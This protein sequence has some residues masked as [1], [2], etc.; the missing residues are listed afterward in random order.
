[1]VTASDRAAAAVRKYL[2]GI[3]PGFSPPS[4]PEAVVEERALPAIYSPVAAYLINNECRALFM[5]GE[6]DFDDARLLAVA[7][8]YKTLVRPLSRLE[9]L[10]VPSPGKEVEWLCEAT[11]AAALCAAVYHA[12][13]DD[14]LNPASL[15]RALG[16]AVER[17]FQVRLKRMGEG[18]GQMDQVL[19]KHLLPVWTLAAEGRELIRPLVRALNH[20]L[21]AALDE[22]LPPAEDDPAERLMAERVRVWKK[23]KVWFRFQSYEYVEDLFIKKRAG[24]LE[25]YQG[26]YALNQSPEAKVDRVRLRVL[27]AHEN[28]QV[29]GKNPFAGGRSSMTS[30]RGEFMFARRTLVEQHGLNVPDMAWAVAECQACQT[31]SRFRSEEDPLTLYRAAQAM[32]R[33]KQMLVGGNRMATYHC[34]RCRQPLGFEHLILAAYAHHL[35]D[36]GRDIYFLN[37]RR[38]GRRRSFI[39]FM[40]EGE[41]QSHA[42][43]ITDQ[44]IAKLAGRP[45]SVVDLWRELLQRTVKKPEWKE[46]GP[47]FVGL[48]LP[49]MSP[50]AASSTVN[51]F[52]DQLVSKRPGFWPV[53]LTGP[54]P[55]AGECVA[56]EYP[57]WLADLSTKVSCD[58]GYSLCAFADM[59]RI[60]ALFSRAAQKL[61]LMPRRAFDGTL[62]VHGPEMN[63]MVDLRNPV[64]L[65][66]LR[67]HFPGT[68]AAREAGLQAKRLAHAESTLQAVRAYLGRGFSVQYNPTTREVVMEGRSGPPFGIPLDELVRQ[69]SDDQIKTRRMIM[70]KVGG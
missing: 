20:L 69:W 35:A 9:F 57:A 21:R 55:S 70:A 30:V 56:H 16:A 49:P 26:L 2:E 29:P 7:A 14:P 19:E 60:E 66:V 41:N 37:E 11:P 34:S 59:D 48:A 62:E 52:H 45:L 22:A 13:Q 47:G 15:A 50:Q 36:Q 5:T 12:G 64:K 27:T 10:T 54:D 43:A 1:M 51:K 38:P 68:F 25:A 28:A 65:A 61:G 33:I 32:E 40:S 17:L 23:D 58:G 18:L 53:P 3:A 44:S 4:C 39:Q 6:Y 63:L 31:R 46:F 42:I 24:L 8:R 67:G